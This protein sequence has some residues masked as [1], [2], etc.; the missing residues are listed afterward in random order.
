V[1]LCGFLAGAVGVLL[2]T[3]GTYA[4]AA[5][6]EKGNGGKSSGSGI[7]KDASKKHEPSEEERD[8]YTALRTEFETDAADREALLESVLERDPDFAPARWARGEVRFKD[9]WV[10]YE[11]FVAEQK[12]PAWNA[13]REFRKPSDLTA[14]SQMRVADFCRKNK[15]PEQERGHLRGVVMTEPDNPAARKRLGEVRVDDGWLSKPDFELR[16]NHSRAVADILRRSKVPLTRISLQLKSG[17]MSQAEALNELK[18]FGEI[19]HIPSLELYLS[20]PD[21]TGAKAVVALLSEQTNGDASISLVRHAL[22]HPSDTVRKSAIQSLQKRDFFGFVPQLLSA[23]QSPVL[24]REGLV[25]LAPGQVMWRQ[26]YYVDKQD[27]QQLAVLDN[28]FHCTAENQAAPTWWMYRNEA[29]L[30]ARSLDQINH[31]IVSSN[32]RISSLLAQVSGKAELRTPDDWWR[33][34]QDENET[35]QVTTKDRKCRRHVSHLCCVIPPEP[36]PAERVVAF[37]DRLPVK[38]SCL[39][40]GTEIWTDSGPVAVELIRTGD[41][42]LSQHPETGE[43]AYKAVIEPTQRPPAVLLKITLEDD[44]RIRSTGGHNFWVAGHG[45]L[46]ARSLKKGMALHTPRGTVKVVDVKEEESQ[47]KAFNLVVSDFH[48]YFVG[49]KRVY[50]YD[51]TERQPS[52]VAVPGLLED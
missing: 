38:M 47:T 52:L 7:S 27:T 9:R 19:E 13:Y 3:V 32:E 14:A 48:T 24:T 18:D 44:E 8:V 43:L 46:K 17:D 45:W 30:R 29:A 39:A 34:W 20:T 15:L 51:N 23:L 31:D 36:P 5:N 41:L 4:T 11:D 35:V 28:V 26:V 40:P 22:A 2:I 49:N 6:P 21:V 25:M 37:R 12:S 33:W 42:V 16:K 1:P 50:S 10:R